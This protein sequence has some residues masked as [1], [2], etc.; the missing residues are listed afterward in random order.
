[1]SYD[2]LKPLHDYQQFISYKIS[3]HKYKVIN[4]AAT[5]RYRP[6]CAEVL[7]KVNNFNDKIE[8]MEY[9]SEERKQFL[10]K[11]YQYWCDFGKLEQKGLMNTQDFE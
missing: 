7:S 8:T 6:N 4:I 3:Q 9:T 1:M 10:K 11:R 2:R 5:Y